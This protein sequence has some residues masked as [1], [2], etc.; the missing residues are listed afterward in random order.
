MN[1]TIDHIE[2]I[3]EP[4]ESAMNT[5]KF[6]LWMFI[7]TIVMLFAALTSAY[8]V[9]QGEG[10]WLEFQLPDIFWLNSAV[11]IC[12]SLF[13]QMAYNSARKNRIRSLK[14]FMFITLILGIVF[15]FGQYI[16]WRDL[17]IQDVYFVGNPA[18]SFLYVLTGLHA[19]HLVSGLIFLIIVLHL[20]FKYKVHSKDMT[21]MEMST[22]YWH[23][24]GGLWLYLFFFLKINH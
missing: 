16:S 5:S 14:I 2:I 1:Q 19:I 4:K 13:M 22:I 21:R 9:K 10:N 11:I 3:R 15:L 18:G 8:I 24:L 17:V 6:I 23:F 7:V 12:S 20:A